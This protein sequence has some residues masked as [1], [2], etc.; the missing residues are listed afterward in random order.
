M[1][2]GRIATSCT[3][4]L[5][6]IVCVV[7]T[8][9]AVAACYDEV[10]G[11][12]RRFI[13]DGGDAR[14][15]KTSLTWKRCSLGMTWDGKGCTGEQS[16]KTL[17][18]AVAAAKISGSGWRVPSGPELQSIVD[19]G[20]GQPVVDKTVFPDI[21]VTR[22]EPRNTGPQILSAPLIWSISLIS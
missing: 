18:E 13:L 10:G 19:R 16:L 2:F 9:E 17:A 20:C 5:A 7:L 21:A 6:V 15:T 12:Q 1:P 4:P 8:G 11:V 3:A 14:D 22:K